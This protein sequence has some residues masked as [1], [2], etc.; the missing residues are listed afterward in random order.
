[1]A[2]VPIGPASL[3]SNMQVPIDDQSGFVISRHAL[4]R[5]GDFEGCYLIN[6]GE[7]KD[8]PAKPLL[9]NRMPAINE[10]LLAEISAVGQHDEALY[11][12]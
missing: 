12:Y 3:K 11:L 8:S 10:A 7:T 2:G 1:M 5:D 4:Y 6:L 9:I